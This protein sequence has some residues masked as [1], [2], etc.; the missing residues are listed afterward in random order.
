MTTKLAV[1]KRK[2]SVQPQIAMDD[3]RLDAP[4]LKKTRIEIIPLIDVVF[5]LLATFVLFTLSLDRTGAIGVQLPKGRDVIPP[6]ADTTAY[7]QAS[8]NGTFYWKVGRDSPA[9]VISAPEIPIRLANY[10]DQVAEPRVMVRGDNKAKFSA[11]VLILDQVRLA[12]I[13]AV[14]IETV[15]SATGR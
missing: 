13:S 8:D 9:E 15:P 1:R 12:G 10:R 7:I 14:S 11:T 3:I 4:L 6:G 5:F 2:V